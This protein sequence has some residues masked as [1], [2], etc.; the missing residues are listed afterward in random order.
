MATFLDFHFLSLAWNSQRSRRYIKN[1][2]KKIDQNKYP[3]STL[4][5]FDPNKKVNNDTNRTNW[6]H[7]FF[8]F[9]LTVRCTRREHDKPLVYLCLHSFSIARK[10]RRVCVDMSRI[11]NWEVV[12]TSHQGLAVGIFAESLVLEERK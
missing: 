9:Y 11:P 2:G 1:S 3:S 7:Y 4:P 12:A 5:L 6:D 8:F 10:Q